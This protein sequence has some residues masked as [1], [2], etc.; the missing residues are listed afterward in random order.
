MPNVPLA[1]DPSKELHSPVL[2]TLAIHGGQVKIEREI[3]QHQS[4]EGCCEGTRENGG[5]NCYNLHIIT[6]LVWLYHKHIQLSAEE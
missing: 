2:S 1:S 5:A 4:E 3:Y 6:A